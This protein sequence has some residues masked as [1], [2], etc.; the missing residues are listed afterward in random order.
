[1]SGQEKHVSFQ[2]KEDQPSAG[3]GG[4]AA[5]AVETGIEAVAQAGSA[6]LSHI[7]GTDEYELQKCKKQI[8]ETGV[9]R[10]VADGKPMPRQQQNIEESEGKEA[11]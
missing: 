9:D 5:S 4:T 7:P 2:S 6:V 3:V 11:T 10:H 1:M 8:E